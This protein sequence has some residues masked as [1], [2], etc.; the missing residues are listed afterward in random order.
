MPGEP[1]GPLRVAIRDV[2]FGEDEEREHEA[3]TVGDALGIVRISAS[4]GIAMREVPRAGP[5]APW[6]TLK[7]KLSQDDDVVAVDGDASATFVVFTRDADDT[8]PG[9]VSSSSV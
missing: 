6:R 8:C 4:G 3:F 7:H 9:A 1:A 2:D 5:V